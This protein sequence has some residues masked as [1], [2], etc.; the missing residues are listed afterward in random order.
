MLNFI[1]LCKFLQVASYEETLTILPIDSSNT[2]NLINITDQAHLPLKAFRNFGSFPIPIF[3]TLQHT[4]EFSLSLTWGTGE[5]IESKLQ[6]YKSSSSRQVSIPQPGLSGY[7]QGRSWEA[8]KEMISGSL[9]TSFSSRHNLIFHNAKYYFSDTQF[10]CRENFE[11]ILD[12]L[13][14]RDSGLASLFP[15]LLT[16]KYLSIQIRAVKSFD[17]YSYTLVVSAL[18]KEK[19]YSHLKSCNTQVEV[20]EDQVLPDTLNL[21]KITLSPVKSLKTLVFKQH[22]WLVDQEHGFSADFFHEF[23]NDSEKPAKVVWFETF[24]VSI[25]PLLSTCNFKVKKVQKNSLGW[26][27]KFEETI[28]PGKSL[29]V[30]KLDKRML[31]FEEYPNDPQRGWDILPSPVFWGD[32]KE[33]MSNGLLVMIPEPDF[34]MPFNVICICGSVIAFF[35]TSFQNL[36][37]WKDSVH[38]TNPSYENTILKAKKRFAILKNIILVISLLVMFYLDQ[39]GIIKMFG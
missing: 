34:S 11:K 24:P 13:P 4:S 2:L 22:R 37:T 31:G 15:Q 29:L 7:I 19:L 23:S 12:W 1:L 39:K 20:F 27:L 16:S 30:M 36:Q 9:S 3:Q 38:W 8:F 5:L 10:L 33:E 17:V 32:G 18:K 35:F 28:D 21:N 14:C 6:D 26:V 25:I